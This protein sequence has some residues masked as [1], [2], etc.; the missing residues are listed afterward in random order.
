ML[1]K[2][3][4]IEHQLT[5]TERTR[6]NENMNIAIFSCINVKHSNRQL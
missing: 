6:Y 4:L 2:K 1:E 5:E 3:D